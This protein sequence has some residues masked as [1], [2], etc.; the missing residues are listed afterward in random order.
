MPLNRA[1]RPHRRRHQHSASSPGKTAPRKTTMKAIVRRSYGPPE[2]L[3]AAEIEKPTPG[4]GEVLVRVHAASINAAD[5]LMMLGEP[6]LVRLGLG[7]RKPKK[8][9]QGRDVAGTVIET[10]AKVSEFEPGDEVYAEADTG[11]FAEFVVVPQARLAPKPS[12]LT[13]EQAAAVPLAGTTAL[14]GIH[15]V[16]QVKPGDRVLVNGASG[17][18]GTFAVQ[19]AKAR[20]A[21]VTAVCSTRNRSLM[22]SL[23]ADHI[24]DYSQEDFAATATTAATGRK[25]DV[26]LDLVGNRSLRDLRRALTPTGTLVL[27]SSG[28]SRTWGPI[29]SMLRALTQAVFTRQRLKALAARANGRSL[30]QLT[31]LIEA[32]AVTP[33][34]QHTYPLAETRE[35]MRHLSDNHAQ[36]KI[37]ISVLPA[38]PALTTPGAES[39]R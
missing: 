23:G 27:A 14:Q 34:I 10:G 15:D 16:A 21:E 2:V 7:L 29:G 28:N 11:T 24:I 35:A 19:I 18:V 20:G 32:G 25:Y 8:F 33:V 30:V 12:N 6:H 39:P 13:F 3:L 1:R 26:I 22:V 38:L 17:G 31:E 37:V 9:G 36:G 4:D 5:R